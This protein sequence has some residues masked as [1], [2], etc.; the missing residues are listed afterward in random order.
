M[1]VVK[2]SVGTQRRAVLEAIAFGAFLRDVETYVDT[3]YHGLLTAN[4]SGSGGFGGGLGGDT[5]GGD[6]GGGSG[7]AKVKPA[8]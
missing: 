8:A 2:V 5:R 1:D 7:G 6:D 4:S 3:D